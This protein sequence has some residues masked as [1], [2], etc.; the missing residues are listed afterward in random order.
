MTLKSMLLATGLAFVLVQPAAADEF[1]EA[2]DAAKQAYEEGDFGAVR[3]ELN[4]AT[5]LLAQMRGDE[6]SNVLPE[7]LDGWTA[8]QGGG[9]GGAAVFGGVTVSRQYRRDRDRVTVTIVT[10]SPAMQGMI[11]IMSNPA[12][13]QSQGGRMERIKRQKAVIKY[14]EKNRRGDI[15][16]VVKQTLV[17]IE[18]TAERDELVA[19]AKA[20][21][22]KKLKAL[23]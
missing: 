3:E 17:T 8:E 20:I 2:L 16:I 22:F 7:P 12:I 23:P 18:G 13:A 10:D 9:G 15:N 4:Y 19:Y 6:L 5:G 14:N 21:D 1:L 11:A